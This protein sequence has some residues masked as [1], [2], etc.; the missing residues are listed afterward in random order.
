[1]SER[2]LQIHDLRDIE[3]IESVPLAARDLPRSTYEVLCRTA[4][5]HPDRTALRFLPC[6]DEPER[7]IRLTYRGLLERVN[8][9]ANLLTDLG[10]GPRDVV[11]ILLPNRPQTHF[12]LWGGEA[13][14]IVSPI[15]PRL[16][17]QQIEAILQASGAKVLITQGPGSELWDKALQICKAVPSLSAI[18][19]ASDQAAE[20]AA[21]RGIGSAAVYSLDEQLGR[22]PAHRL[23]RERPIEPADL[24]A[25]F[26]TG[27]TTAAPKLARHTHGNEVFCAWVLSQCLGMDAC[28]VVLCGLPLFHVNAA[29]LTGL[30]PFSVGAEVV[31]LGEDG[32]RRP[33]TI[34][35]FWDIA[36]RYR[37]TKFSCVPTVL[38]RLL[39]VPLGGADLSALRHAACGAAPLSPELFRAFESRT[40]VQLL[41]GYGLTE[42]GVVSCVNPRHGERRIGSIGLRIPYQEVRL[43]RPETA[44]PYG[45]AEPR[46][47]SGPGAECRPG[48]TGV[49][50]IRG[51][52][53]FSGYVKP[54]Q[55]PGVL[56]TD[57]WLNTGDLAR[58][59]AD[60]YF[61][62]V[63]R[64]K[65]VIIRG[66]H[67]IDPGVI[68]EALHRHGAVALAAAVGKPDPELGELP[69]AYVQL[70][71]GLRASA[72]EL[73]LHVQATI[74]EAAA[75]PKEIFL[76][77]E[78]P[79]TAVGKIWKPALRWD[80]TARALRA[81]LEPVRPPG[82][83]LEV[84][85]AA[86][87]QRGT[88]ARIRLCGEGPLPEA[89][90][91]AVQAVLAA[92][93]VPYEIERMS[94]EAAQSRSRFEDRS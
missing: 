31:L 24:A 28:D 8:Q 25:Y 58:Q 89:S 22:Y 79:Q 93:A 9:T 76:I 81:A 85:V 91:L 30:A 51:P 68:E 26:H 5:L 57:G 72:R 60:G 63:G 27:G 87:E 74:G 50:Y 6:T 78:M 4:A 62:I 48:E 33:A 2:P 34:S 3:R 16:K 67:N 77:D 82:H 59:D 75:A 11:A 45:G 40:G 47:E 80:A 19:Q 46:A 1:M 32:Y 49:L 53:V 29:F 15:N 83:E 44:P 13:A 71:P 42:G 86:D 7:S 66:G 18:L 41:E 73:L 12:A 90:R 65:D 36:A 70:K 17:P 37:A 92:Y 38:T 20:P 69:V 35:R 10:V 39:Q 88:L 52:N 21:V 14:G 54:E 61:Y 84:H 56:G 23:Q 43:V 94:S 64:A 55:D